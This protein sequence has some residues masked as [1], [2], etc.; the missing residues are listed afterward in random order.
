MPRASV[1]TATPVKPGFL[2]RIRIPNR[3]P[4][5]ILDVVHPAHV[6]ALLFD[7]FDAAQLA[8]GRVTGFLGVIPFATFSSIRF[9]EV[10]AEFVAQLLL[11]AARLKSERSRNGNL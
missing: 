7:L 5:E 10:E 3:Y 11:H 2:A 4:N 1:T 6:A 8:Q 9:S